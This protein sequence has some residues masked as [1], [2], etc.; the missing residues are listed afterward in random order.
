MTLSQF[1]VMSPRGDTIIS[2]DFRGDCP[3][4]T[5]EVFFRRHKFWPG[6][7]PPIFH[8]DGVN[9][10]HVRKS[11]LLFV[12]TTK[13]NT[14][15]SHA[16][17][18][19][20][21]ITRVFKD[22][23][24]VLTE[25]SIRKNFVL[26][27]ELLDEMLDFGLAQGTSTE[28]LKAYVHNEPVPVVS[29]SSA[30]QQLKM[31]GSSSKTTPSSAVHKPIAVGTTRK[32]KGQKNEIF[33]DILERLSLT[34]N[35]NGY[36]LNSSIDGCIQMKSYLSG[37]PALRI[38]LNE[39]LAVGKA[40][41]AQYGAVVLDDCN[42]HECVNLD[43]FESGRVLNLVPPDGEFVVMNYRVT[44]EFRPPFRVF[45]LVEE[46]SPYKLEVIV[47]IR[48]DIPDSNYGSNVAVRF[49]VPRT[50]SSASAQLAPGVQGQSA[51]YDERERQVT[52]Q[53]KK[54][55]G[56]AEHT[57]K[58]T[59]TLSSPC[60][61]TTRREIGPVSLTFEVPMFNASHLQV[62]YLRIAEASKSYKP[63][64]WVRY[65]TQSN[66]YVCRL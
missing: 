33:V 22:Y 9:Y 56:G 62:R 1:F 27:Y 25:E 42:F 3:R 38:A 2:R 6:D 55:Q 19:L 20:Q 35:S 64:R 44:S 17:E 47:K 31:T 16:L 14:S 53:I 8:D 34:F 23:C 11:G 21:R 45:P 58:T 29:S 5:S 43:E 39:D 18:L 46:L 50:S 60:S 24:G 40:Q 12:A 57:L 15:P 54:F 36:I 41:G 49:A 66:S 26:V 7:A 52:W 13:F 61:A 51:D 65:V 37:N 32:T 10:I 4:G 63:Y 28:V 48:A 59:I 30:T